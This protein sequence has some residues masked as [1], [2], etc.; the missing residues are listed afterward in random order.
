MKRSSTW[1]R[2]LW[3]AGIVCT[4]LTAGTLM[5]SSHREAPMIAYDPEADNTDVYA[6][7]NP[8]VANSVII[9]ANYIPMQ[10]PQGAPNFYKFGEDVRYEIHVDNDVTTPGDDLTYRF[11]FQ[12][13]NEDPTTIFPMRLKKE[14][15]KN[16]YKL[17]RSMD[18]GKT[19]ETI[20]TNGFVPPYNAGE[21]SIQSKYGLAVSDY[22]LLRQKAVTYS[23]TGEKVFVGHAD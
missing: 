4:V 14:N 7:R 8:T 15:Q 11:T 22:E 10:L 1:S 21:R 17:E 12:K 6:F 16:T 19:F 13:V 5:S 23:S 18:G 3:P 20:V 2:L 9:I